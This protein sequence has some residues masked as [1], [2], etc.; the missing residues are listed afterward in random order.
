MATPP[1]ISKIVQRMLFVQYKTASSNTSVL[2]KARYR[3]TQ[4]RVQNVKFER[5]LL[6]T[7]V[8][9]PEKGLTEC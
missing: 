1:K 3:I 9:Q 6:A 2:A 5:K 8:T 4:F 7:P